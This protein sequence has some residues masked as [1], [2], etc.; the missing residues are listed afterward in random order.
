MSQRLSFRNLSASLGGRAVLHQATASFDR[1]GLVALVGPNGAGKTTL[2]KSLVGLVSASGEIALDGAR[3]ET[4]STRERALRVGY[5][6]QGHAIH[7]PLPARDVVALGRYARGSHDPSRL[8]ADDR[9]A[10]EAAMVATGTAEFAD[11]AVT[12]LSGGERARIAL[13]RVLAAETPIVLAD[14]PITSLDPHYQI[15]V[16]TLLKR[17]ANDGRLVI[18]V[19]HDL[20]LAWRYADRVLALD[21]GRIAADG[22]PHAAL[23]SDLLARVFGVTAAVVAHDGRSI[24]ATL[25]AI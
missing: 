2:L 13:A 23:S 17:I 16:M 25:D 10:V 6:P 18:V 15:A 20:A 8:S 7:W 3:A 9:R 14:E 4:L 11:R 21:D 19:L 1:N 12:E 5:L 24:L 22:E